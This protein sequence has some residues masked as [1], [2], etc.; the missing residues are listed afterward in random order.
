MT[1]SSQFLQSFGEI[2]NQIL[3][4]KVKQQSYN[5]ENAIAVYM[6]DATK[7][8]R[9]TILKMQNQEKKQQKE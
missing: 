6:K 5:G 2:P 1:S 8:I 9:N 4:I 7:K 3:Q